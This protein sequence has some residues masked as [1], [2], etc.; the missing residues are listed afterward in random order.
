MDK[1]ASGKFNPFFNDS[2]PVLGASPVAALIFRSF[3][4]LFVMYLKM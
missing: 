2:S 3:F 4:F 1:L